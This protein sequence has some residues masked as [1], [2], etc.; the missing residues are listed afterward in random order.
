MI[1]IEEIEEIEKVQERTGEIEKITEYRK[2]Y[3]I[4][5]LK[6]P[7]AWILEP[8]DMQ[9]RILKYYK[10]EMKKVGRGEKDYLILPSDSPLSLELI[11]LKESV[12]AQEETK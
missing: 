10:D 11:A 2:K 4:P 1:K 5:V 12:D 8:T 9:A 3:G 7:S 6:V